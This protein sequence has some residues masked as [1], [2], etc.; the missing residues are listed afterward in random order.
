MHEDRTPARAPRVRFP[1]GQLV[2]TPA[3]LAA[4]AATDEQPMTFVIRHLAGD[5]GDLDVADAQANDHALATGGRLLSA[6]TLADGQKLWI[7]PEADRGVT[8]LL[9]PEDY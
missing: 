7:L 1:V 2:A 5:W 6:Y 9:L 8:T 4:L 3:A